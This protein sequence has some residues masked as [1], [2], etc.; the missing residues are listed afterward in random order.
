MKGIRKF[1]FFIALLFVCLFVLQMHLPKKFV[2]SPTFSHVDKQ[3]FGCYVF[4][5]VLAQSLPNGYQTTRQTFLQ[6]NQAHQEEKVAVL[7]VMEADRFTSTDVSHLL[8]IAKRGGKVMLVYSNGAENSELGKK[9]HVSMDGYNSF[10]LN[11]LLQSITR[12]E[13]HY[14]TLYWN[15]KDNV[16]PARGYKVY[17]ELLG[18]SIS[19][20]TAHGLHALARDNSEHRDTI[21]ASVPFGKGEV[22]LVATPLLFTNYGMLDG[23]TSEYIFRLMSQIADLP[24]YRTEAY[25]QTEAMKEAEQSP[26]REFI[27][28]P[29]LRWALY[30]ALLGVI[31]FMI[32]TARRRQRVIPIISPPSN[33]S[34]EFVKLIGTL[35]YQRHDHADLV[36]KKFR[37]FAEEVRRKSDV[38]I[39]D[40]N[41]D[42][43]EYSLLAEKT[44]MQQAELERV[45]REI[46]LVIHSE[47]NISL[48]EMRRLI[49]A[50]ND[51]LRR[52]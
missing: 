38:D 41:Y 12:G 11:Y 48:G 49:D 51:I 19:A 31:L 7:S 16:Y 32:F 15:P 4:D 14:D 28:R 17:S 29:A 30:L 47:Q 46:R 52:L 27:K 13:E 44:G 36:R 8:A 10:D 2:W 20:D 40:V 37:L 43:S 39:S 23:N 3:P 33:K 5:S 42:G 6:I 21:A 9:L 22:L 50:M 18:S 35:Y 26:L 24:V 25:M 1:F 34:L 45:L